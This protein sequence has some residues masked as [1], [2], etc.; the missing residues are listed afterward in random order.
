MAAPEGLQ[1]GQHQ[2]EKADAVESPRS[3]R[4]R[5]EVD[6]WRQEQRLWLTSPSGLSETAGLQL[7]PESAASS[8]PPS[9]A[10]SRTSAGNWP[11]SLQGRRGRSQ[12]LAKVGLPLCSLAKCQHP[13]H[14]A[15]HEGAKGLAGLA[16]VQ[17]RLPL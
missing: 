7:R 17:Q 10:E 16:P 15:T 8:A 9:R 14:Q 4:G 1:E 3:V 2:Q 12:R 13:R 6:D 5:Q 11:A